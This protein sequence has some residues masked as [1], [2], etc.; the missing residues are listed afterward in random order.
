MLKYVK[1]EEALLGIAREARRVQAAT[2]IVRW[3]RRGRANDTVCENEETQSIKH[4]DVTGWMRSYAI[5]ICFCMRAVVL[6]LGTRTPEATVARV[7][8]TWRLSKATLSCA[9]V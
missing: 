3:V 6:F 4:D 1:L 8:V 2:T 5:E 7:A 9:I